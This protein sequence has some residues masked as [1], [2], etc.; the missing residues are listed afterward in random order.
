MLLHTTINKLKRK[1]RKYTYSTSKII[2]LG[3]LKEGSKRLLKK[4]NKKQEIY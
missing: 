1:L 4:Q 3:I 2:N